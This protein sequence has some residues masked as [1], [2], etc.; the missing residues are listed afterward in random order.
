MRKEGREGKEA[1][2]PMILKY[3]RLF[4]CPKV[5]DEWD[6]GSAN[7]FQNSCSQKEYQFVALDS[8][9]GLV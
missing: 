9:I 3:L 5:G 4:N 6:R 7:V 8:G 2:I 1:K